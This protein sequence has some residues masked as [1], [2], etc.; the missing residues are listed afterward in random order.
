[1]IKQSEP[2]SDKEENFAN[3]KRFAQVNGLNNIE[4][5]DEF[6]GKYKAKQRQNIDPEKLIDLV[7]MV[8]DNE[9]WGWLTASLF[10]FGTRSGETFHSYPT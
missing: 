1:M 3:Y 9:K 2:E 4:L 8:R 5:I 6:V 7:D 10:V